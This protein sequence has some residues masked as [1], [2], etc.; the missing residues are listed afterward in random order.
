MQSSPQTSFRA[1]AL[2]G[3][4]CKVALLSACST[5]DASAV[6]T[7]AQRA[8]PHAGEV[9][10]RVTSPPP[11][12]VE[13]G[14]VEVRAEQGEATVDTMMPAFL[15]KVRSL[16]GN[17]A[18]VDAIT[19]R[20]DMSYRTHVESYVYPCGFRATCVGTRHY[21]ASDEVMIVTMRGR[22]FLAKGGR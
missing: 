17:V 2:L 15:W 3:A 4:M 6:R 11:E 1:A 13:L 22:A 10:I 16:G 20:F 18:V 14:L 8:E 7:G 12:G 21:P 9:S 5:I 19:T